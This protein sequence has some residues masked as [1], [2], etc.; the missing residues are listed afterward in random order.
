MII[1]IIIIIIM[2]IMI[3][4]MIMIMIMMVRV[5]LH[6]LSKDGQHLPVTGAAG[7]LASLGWRWGPAMVTLLLLTL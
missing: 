4:I 6:V 3:I 5:Q 2:I 1:V 7:T